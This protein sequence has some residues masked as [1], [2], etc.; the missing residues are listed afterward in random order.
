MPSIKRQWWVHEAIE[1]TTRYREFGISAGLGAGKTFG[2]V[3]WHFNRTQ[4]NKNCKFSAFAMPIYQK[5]HDAAIP[6]YEKYLQARGYVYGAH[7]KILKTP[8]PK[9]VF[10]NGHEVHFISANRPDRMVAVEYSHAV[11]SE[12]GAYEKAALDLITTRVRDAQAQILQTMFE[13]APQGITHFATLFDEAQSAGWQEIADRDYLNANKNRRRFRLTSFDNPYLPEGYVDKLLS[14]Y[15]GNQPY[16]NSY[17]YG[18]FCPLVEG[19]AYNYF[20]SSLVIEDIEASPHQDIFL[21]W[22]FNANPLAWVALQQQTFEEYG[23]RKK[24]FIAIDEANQQSATLSQACV[25]FAFKFAPER[26][27]N[28]R[29]RVHGDS[30]GHA[31]SHKVTHSDYEQ[32]AKFLRELGFKNV[33]I[34]AAKSNPPETVSVEAL[35]SWLRNDEHYINKRCTNYQRSLIMTRWRE[36]VKKLDKP[37][38]DKWTHWADAVKYLAW[39]LSE[40]S[41]TLGSEYI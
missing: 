1:D 12:S 24:R 39:R 31:S 4:Q 7:Y 35:N 21:T 11:C 15:E 19:S 6:T 27:G 22:D 23:Y 33:S 14:I 37:A 3:D 41:T 10:N 25:E 16:I 18:I 29:I 9:L 2:S 26:F 13:G 40:G 20:N 36:G 30:S 8:F 38:N 34:E 28:T 32:I 5:I 17:V